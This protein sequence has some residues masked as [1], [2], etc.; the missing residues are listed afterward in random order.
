MKSVGVVSVLPFKYSVL[1]VCAYDFHCNVEPG[2]ETRW[3]SHTYKI[4]SWKIKVIR[5]CVRKR[6]RNYFSLIRQLEDTF[7]LQII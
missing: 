1:I 4:V 2:P 7:E 6:K 5:K 3:T